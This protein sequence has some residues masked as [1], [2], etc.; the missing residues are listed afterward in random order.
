M[1]RTCDFF[2]VYFLCPI[3]F[4]YVASSLFSFFL[5][6]RIVAVVDNKTSAS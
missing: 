1:K 6:P 2:F 4:E 3:F 5:R